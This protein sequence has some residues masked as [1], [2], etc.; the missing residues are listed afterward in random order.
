MKVLRGP[1]KTVIV[2]MEW[3]FLFVVTV[4]GDAQNLLR[5]GLQAFVVSRSI[6]SDSLPPHRL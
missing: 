3:L 4:L 5:Q 6:V 2:H 1:W